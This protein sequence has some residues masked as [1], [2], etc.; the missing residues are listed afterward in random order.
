MNWHCCEH[1]N[2]TKIFLIFQFVHKVEVG[3]GNFF[4]IFVSYFC[5]PGSTALIDP[6]TKHCNTANI[7]QLY[8]LLHLYWSLVFNFRIRWALY[9]PCTWCRLMKPRPGW[10]SLGKPYEPSHF[11]IKQL[12]SCE[13]FASLFCTMEV[14][15]RRESR[16]FHTYTGTAWYC[17]G[18]L[19][20]SSDFSLQTS[21]PKEARAGWWENSPECGLDC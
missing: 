10:P 21:K 5:S 15:T 2:K 18:R 20:G 1:K 12:A 14:K 11:Y 19:Q 17:I 16:L 6:D 13:Y 3:S 7:I 8:C 9:P 4:S